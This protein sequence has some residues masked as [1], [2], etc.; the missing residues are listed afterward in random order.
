MLGTVILVL[1]LTFADDWKS[2]PDS[3]WKEKLSP[4][5]YE[6]CRRGGT[7]R[8]FSGSCLHIKDPGTYYCSS[9]GLELF[10]SDTKFNSGTGWPSFTEATKKDAITLQP[11]NSHGMQRTEVRCGRCGA[12][13]GHV[14]NDGP[15]PTGK[16]Y[17][18]NS[19]CLRFVKNKK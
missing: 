18:I 10:K 9:C 8:A 12:H 4:Q 2:K 15:P 16:R 13:L 17:C 6:V 14:F 5:E 11:D 7:E 3:Y 1:S 19:V